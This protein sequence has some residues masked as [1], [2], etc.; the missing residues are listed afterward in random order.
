MTSLPLRAALKRGVLTVVANWPVVLIDFTADSLHKLALSVPVLGGAVMVAALADTEPGAVVGE[1]LRATADAILGSLA[2][3]PSGLGAFLLAVAIV[4]IGGEAIVFAVK[5]GTLAVLVASDRT[6]GDFD[7]LPIDA[8]T[9]ARAR[10]WRPEAVLDGALHFG[11]RA[12]RLALWLGAGYLVIGGV[13]LVI[14]MMGLWAAAT[15]WGA[16]WPLAV[17]LAT[18]GGILAIAILNLTFDLLRVIVVTDDCEVRVALGRLRRF[19]IEDARHVIGI[20]AVMGLIE[21]VAALASLLAATGLAVVGYVPLVS[22]VFAP[23]RAAAWVLRGL[24]FEALAL[25]ALAAYQTQYRRY[26]GAHW[27]VGDRPP[28]NPAAAGRGA[29]TSPDQREAPELPDA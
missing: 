18:S 4:A 20:F 6:S 19:A 7:R 11:H 26:A 27:P 12:I 14:V 3:A 29:A 21:L 13:Y 1:G 10:R 28:G 16:V 17:L 9:V 23:L 5:T 8:D 24:L 2:T 22:V 15:T 25:S